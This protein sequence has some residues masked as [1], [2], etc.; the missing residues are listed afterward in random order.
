MGAT[1]VFT[2]FLVFVEVRIVDSVLR[3][4]GFN[5]RYKSPHITV[6]ELLKVKRGISDPGQNESFSN[7]LSPRGKSLV[8]I[9]NLWK[10]LSQIRNTP[11][12]GGT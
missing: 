10:S 2:W 9:I 1:G 3:F 8:I 5:K 6:S 4:R 12:V 11:L 7:S